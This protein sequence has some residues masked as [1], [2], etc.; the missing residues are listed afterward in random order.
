MD[1]LFHPPTPIS[2]YTL[3]FIHYNAHVIGFPEEGGGNI[4]DKCGNFAFKVFC[5]TVET[6]DENVFSSG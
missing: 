2:L 3:I 4:W 6:E 1:T 5:E